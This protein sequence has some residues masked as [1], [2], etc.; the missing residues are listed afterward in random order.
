M[1]L[2]TKQQFQEALSDIIN[3]L[4]NYY[5][6][7]KSGLKI[8]VN[9]VKYGNAIAEFEGFARI[10][11]GLAP[12][13]N[14]GANEPEFEKIYLEGI[15][16]G[17]DR[18]HPDYWGDFSQA[19]QRMVEMAAIG[20]AL[21]M[22][23]QKIWEPLNKCQKENLVKWLLQMNNCEP[24][25]NNWRFFPIF[26]NLGLKHVGA[27]YSQEVIDRSLERIHSFY[28][29]NG[30]YNDGASG[31]KRDY[32]VAFAFHFY[33]LI[34]AKH[35]ESIDPENSKIF[36]ERAMLFAKDF[37]YWFDETG[38]GL[39]FGRSL[40]YRFA[41]SCFWGACV[42]ADVY[43]FAIEVMKGII[44]RNLAWWLSRPIFTEGHF[45]S[46]GYE[47]PL[48]NMAEGYNSPQ[49]PY[50]ALKSF[51]V[52]SLPDEHPFWNAEGKELPDLKRLYSIPNA[53]MVMQRAKDNVIAYTA[54]Q[55]SNFNFVHMS[56]KTAK[57]LYSTKYSFSVPRSYY[58]LEQAATDNMLTIVIDDICYVRRV[59][60]V[61]RIENNQVYSEWSP[62]RGVTVRCLIIPDETGHTRKYH[63][64]STIACTAFDC[65]FAAEETEAHVTSRD[66]TFKIIACEA[67]TNLSRPKTF[68][69]AIEYQV[70]L[71]D[72]YFESHFDNF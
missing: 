21:L 18:N 57:L 33:S 51:I 30:W 35:C 10:L 9:G 64:T 69:Q 32:Y 52:L 46:V 11:W 45:L 44:T 47:Y 60:D 13:W 59:C 72:N 43:P 23:P 8:G 68:I 55:I 39:A 24:C 25:D 17:T 22:A 6:P 38:R 37:I 70:Q 20:Y 49:S 1:K 53:N 12:L 27:Q 65:G 7:S 3:P 29:G 63:I 15:I 2:H 34:Y 42:Y 48:Y 4:K 19:N 61:V 28:I 62:V 50:W 36:K 26:V 71:G 16:H 5:I 56:E 58:K 41:Q 40:T 67:N 31:V 66:G 14:G 54:G